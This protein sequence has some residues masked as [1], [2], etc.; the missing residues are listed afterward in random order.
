M[1]ANVTGK[2]HNIQV[3]P[4][5]QSLFAILLVVL[6]PYTQAAAPAIG[7]ASAGGTF[8]IN[9]ATVSA[10]ATLFDGTR[11]Q[12]G[13]ASSRLQLKDGT[14]VEL[15][16]G[17]RATV[18]GKKLTLEKGLGELKSASGYVIAARGLRIAS[19]D[20]KSTA[21]V[22]VGDGNV[23]LVAAVN[24]PA[25]VF[26]EAGLFITDVK[27]EVPLSL[28]AD[29]Q[30]GGGTAG[31]AGSPGAPAAQYSG[32]LLKIGDRYV[33]IDEAANVFLEVRTSNPAYLDSL[34]GQHVLVDAKPIRCEKPLQ[35]TTEVL[36]V[37][38]I[39]FRGAS[40]ECEAVKQRFLTKYPNAP[41]EARKQKDRCTVIE[42]VVILAAMGIF[43]G[44]VCCN[45]NAKTPVSIP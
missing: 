9:S 36:Q 11:I 15:S 44:L 32:C 45:G 1:V 14:R 22:Q 16:P 7:M 24:G 29:D 5:V 21:R 4:R 38:A 17:A 33:L 6:I 8:E 35:G 19:A 43:L 20:S 39:N 18:F 23:V 30:T 25:K 40:A 13:T 37:K 10:N 12:N 28:E 31:G 41:N 26:N 3:Q 34:T 27:P 2:A 42:G